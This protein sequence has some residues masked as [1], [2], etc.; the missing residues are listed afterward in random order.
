[1]VSENSNK[2]IFKNSIILYIRLAIVSV[3]SILIARFSLQAL[4]I[5]D[6]GLFSLIGGIISIIGLVNTIMISVSN[7]FIATAIGRGNME[8]INKQ[9]NINLIIHVL[10]A[11]FTIICSSTNILPV[12]LSYFVIFTKN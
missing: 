9:F 1:M 4:G 2:S 6:Y 12:I 11:I 7:R 3:C 5:V 10:I 8:E